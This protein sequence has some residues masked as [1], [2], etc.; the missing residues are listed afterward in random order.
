MQRK[1][2]FENYVV[3]DKISYFNVSYNHTKKNGK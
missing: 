3:T 1:R 2:K